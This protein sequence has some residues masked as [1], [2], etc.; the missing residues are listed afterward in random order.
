LVDGV[1]EDIRHRHHSTQAAAADA[2]FAACAWSPYATSQEL[3]RITLSCSDH[4]SAYRWPHTTVDTSPIPW[5]EMACQALWTDSR[6][7]LCGRPE[8]QSLS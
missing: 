5:Y 7:E 3:Q 8:Y 1:V 2:L 4:P 6:H